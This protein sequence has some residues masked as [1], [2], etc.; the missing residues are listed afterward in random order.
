[1]LL[2]EKKIIFTCTAS[3]QRW[4]PYVTVS[5]NISYSYH[6]INGIKN[7]KNLEVKV[8]RNHKGQNVT[9]TA[10]DVHRLE[11]NSS[12]VITLDPYCEYNNSLFYCVSCQ[13]SNARYYT[14]SAFNM[15]T[16]KIID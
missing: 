9:C 1:M 12:N 5:T 14:L 7:E 15:L 3:Q 6:G 8:A 16:V 13:S 4:P 10:I 11:S 2:S